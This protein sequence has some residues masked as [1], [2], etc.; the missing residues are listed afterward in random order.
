MEYVGAIIDRPRKDILE[1]ARN[2]GEFVT[3]YRRA[4]NDRPYN[5]PI[6]LCIKFQFVKRIIMQKKRDAFASLFFR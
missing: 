1:F 4:V 6:R 3:L 2:F 5:I